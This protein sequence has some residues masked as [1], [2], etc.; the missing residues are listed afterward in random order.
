M[1]SIDHDSQSRFESLL[2]EIDAAL[3][4]GE[5]PQLDERLLRDMSLEERRRLEKARDQLER[6]YAECSNVRRRRNGHGSPHEIGKQTAETS[7]SLDSRPEIPA[8]LELAGAFFGRFEVIRPL[9]MGGQGVVFL[10]RE[11]IL[12]RL[13]ALKVPRPDV[14]AE[15][16]LRKRFL[17]EGRASALL[18]HPNIV[19]VFE[20]GEV[21]TVCYLVQDYIAGPSLATWLHDHPH[22]IPPVTVAKIILAL[23]EA[24]AVAHGRQ[25]LHRDIKPGNIL[26]TPTTTD[27]SM[28]DLG[29]FTPKLFDFGLAKILEDQ[30][31]TQT[32]GILGTPAYMA[33]ER[34]AG[35]GDLIGVTSDLYSLGAVLYELLTH[36]PPYQAATPLATLN[37]VLNQDPRPPRSIVPGVPRDLEAI[38]LKCLRRD[39]RER[40]L[41]GLELADD[42]RRFLDG[43]SVL[44]RPR[45]VWRTFCK[46]SR[47]NPTVAL[48]STAFFLTL[49]SLLAGSLWFSAQLTESLKISKKH[50]Q[51]LQNRSK[52][53]RQRVYVD[54]QSHAADAWQSGDLNET[55]RRLDACLPQEGESDLRTFPWWMLNHQ[56]E[57]QSRVIGTIRPG[58]MS[59]S[60]AVSP[61]QKFVA[62][63][64]PD[65]VIRL[66]SIPDG[67]LIAELRGHLPGEINSLQFSPVAEETVLVSAGSD[68][69][70]RVWDLATYEECQ[71]LRLHRGIVYDAKFLGGDSSTIATAGEDRVIR[72]WDRKSGKLQCELKGHTDTIRSLQ[73]QPQAGILF[74]AAEDGS[75]RVWDW[76]SAKPDE[77]LAGGRLFSPYPDIWAR[78]IAL[79][80]D[81][82]R[83]VAGFRS[84]RWIHWNAD[85]NRGDYGKIVRDQQF[86][87]GIRSLAWIDDRKLIVGFGDSRILLERRA[88]LPEGDYQFL[89]GHSDWILSLGVVPG[90]SEF[91]SI[92]KD[93]AIRLWPE[94][95]IDGTIQVPSEIGHVETQPQ[96]QNSI[97]TIA[98]R[99]A[100]FGFS[101][102]EGTQ[103][104]KVSINETLPGA[105]GSCTP[106]G[107][108]FVITERTDQGLYL[109]S[110]IDVMTGERSWQLSI[111][112]SYPASGCFSTDGK[113][114]YVEMDREIWSVDVA[115][116][117]LRWKASHPL[118]VRDV[119]FLRHEQAV[120]TV[121]LDG[122]IRFWDA[123]TGRMEREQRVHQ[124]AAQALA[125]SESGR[126][127]ATAG[128][129]LRAR[130]WRI[131]DWKE[132]ASFRLRAEIETLYFADNDQTLISQGSDE[133]KFWNIPDQMEVIQA[134][135]LPKFSKTTISPDHRTIAVQ[136]DRS[137]RLLRGSP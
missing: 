130:V 40:Y 54:D 53:L 28:D 45:S 32:E 127:V 12:D 83:I 4:Q 74:S 20:S 68:G 115:T 33:P 80:P 112:D 43:G 75:V 66:R 34:A 85:P 81:G 51:E 91:V 113:W 125:V 104:F 22:A 1:T 67:Q 73:E 134:F 48:L 109:F 49:T 61:S 71:V 89:G 70:A 14:L 121:C 30:G 27:A 78:A 29:D 62:C 136:T 77:R 93:G 86:P 98:A 44:A 129:D 35:C 64:E 84:G 41:T 82:T 8:N 5:T 90:R 31:S 118:G 59:A 17:R 69:T 110:A 120:A 128:E 97:L 137:I 18:I 56:L 57:N 16:T 124:N 26:M 117:A 19:T 94:A 108:K 7:A 105:W 36:R 3:H 92:S 38:C 87:G 6:L 100:V 107:S 37:Q 95:E 46:W 60:V 122:H 11:P 10:A 116:G 76:R 106:D 114:I 13:V 52:S 79:S 47:K 101:M 111:A 99:K 132:M 103:R 72:I 88:D 133:F 126:L 50:E 15:P 2:L 131:S 135:S 123:L 21:G 96:W 9:G 24:V 42:L 39:P 25:I 102:P 119:K 65:G 63:G 58:I 55:R 23:A